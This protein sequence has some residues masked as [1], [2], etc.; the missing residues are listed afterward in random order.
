MRNFTLMVLAAGFGTRM[1]HLTKNIPKPLLK[2]NDTTLLT[3]T[4]NYF[5]KLGCNK[6][7]FD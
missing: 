5:E 1:A 4:I 7:I 6:F 3:N 2:I